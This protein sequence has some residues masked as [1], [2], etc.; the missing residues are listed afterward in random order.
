MSIYTCSFT[1]CD[2]A[3]QEC[4]SSALAPEVYECVARTRGKPPFPELLIYAMLSVSL[5]T[6]IVTI[7]SIIVV[8]IRALLSHVHMRVMT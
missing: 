2:G 7:G 4:R 6:S 8:N 1:Q 5:G 3:R